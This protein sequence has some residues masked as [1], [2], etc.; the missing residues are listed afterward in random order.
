V[1]LLVAWSARGE[2]GERNRVG[3]R[4]SGRGWSP[5]AGEAQV[6]EELGVCDLG[7]GGEGEGKRRCHGEDVGCALSQC[8][9]SVCEVRKKR[10]RPAKQGPS[11]VP[12]KSSC[13]RYE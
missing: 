1:F 12:A 10:G 4:K 3:R 11:L 5:A 7:V 8:C 13:Q 2:E 9:R 6:G